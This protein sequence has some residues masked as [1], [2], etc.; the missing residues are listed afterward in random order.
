[1]VSVCPLMPSCNTYRLTWVSLTLDM[2]YL[3]T[4][5]LI[6][7]YGIFMFFP[8]GYAAVGS[9][10]NWRPSREQ[11]D[12][13]AFDNYAWLF[14]N[15]TTLT[16]LGNTLYF[17]VVVVIFRTLTGLVFAALIN[18][19]TRGKAL[20]RTLFFLPVITPTFYLI[21]R[22]DPSCHFHAYEIHAY[23]FLSRLQHF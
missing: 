21:K 15:K 6:V 7:F 9:F 23:R 5:I 19:I 1:M 3:F 10:F 17:T 13:I 2:G 4:V 16:A 14:T 8:I 12:F 20:Y 18:E 22:N 11:F